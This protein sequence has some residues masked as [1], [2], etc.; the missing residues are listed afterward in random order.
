MRRGTRKAAEGPTEQERV[1][2]LHAAI[3][4]ICQEKKI[5]PDVLYDAIEN[6][7]RTACKSHFGKEE[8]IGVEINRETSEFHV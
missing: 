2:E 4:M 6:S 3:M 8:N 1:G 7:L 5:S